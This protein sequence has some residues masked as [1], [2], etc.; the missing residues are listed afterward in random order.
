[1]FCTQNIGF[2]SPVQQKDVHVKGD[3]IS[4]VR[5]KDV[6]Q[7]EHEE[8]D[9][10]LESV[11]AADMISFGLIPEFVGRMPITVPLHSLNEDMLV[12][13][14]TEPQNALVKQYQQCFALDDVS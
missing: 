12:Q 14:L 2:G 13:I 7:Q 3:D 8:K 6:V 11:E 4:S 9:R 10:L 5:D 1:M